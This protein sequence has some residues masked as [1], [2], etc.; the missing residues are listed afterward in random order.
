MFFVAGAMHLGL[1][2]LDTSPVTREIIIG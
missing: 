1:I 2:Y